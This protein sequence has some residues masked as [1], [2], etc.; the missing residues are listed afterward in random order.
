MKLEFEFKPQKELKEEYDLVIIG[1][2]P[3]G[4]SA[5]LYARRFKLSTLIVSDKF[6]GLMTDAEVIDNYPGLPEISGV[7]LA[8]AFLS[9]AKKYGV[10]T[11]E[12]KVVD[13][14]KEDKE[15]VVELRDGKEIRT[16]TIIIAT[17]EEHRRLN[18]LG[19]E[20][21]LGKGVSYCAICDAPLFSEKVVAVIGGGNVAFTSVQILARQAKKVFLIHRR[22]WFRADPIEI[23]RVKKLENV[24]IL[25]PYVVKEI[26]GEKNVE[27]LV[28]EEVYE[29]E[30]EVVGTVKLRELKVD[31]VFV[32]I[33][34]VPNSELAKKMGVKL[35]E[36]GYIETDDFMRT[37]IEGVFAAGDVTSKASKFRQI[38]LAAAQGAIAALS[39]F[40]YLK[41][42]K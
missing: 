4:C 13:L 10:E 16:K 19:E 23:E 28:L 20:K 24:E 40:S 33:G 36:R 1:G 14:R 31:G 27:S 37:D 18:V 25:V 42:K 32:A 22:K 8:K 2:G 9:H 11:Y 3:A 7:K 35:D 41:E 12:S 38:V 15:F 29:K 6:G 5:G 26:K 17:G 34:L 30:G 21:L 39:A